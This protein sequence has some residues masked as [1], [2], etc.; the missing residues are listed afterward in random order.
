MN[1][2]RIKA[3][4]ILGIL[5][6][7]VQPSEFYDRFYSEAR[8]YGISLPTEDPDLVR[9]LS[10]LALERVAG[11]E[12]AGGNHKVVCNDYGISYD[13]SYRLRRH[14]RETTVFV[15]TGE[16][17]YQGLGLEIVVQDEPE[18]AFHF[19][20]VSAE[21]EGEVKWSWAEDG[22]EATLNVEAKDIVTIPQLLDYCKVDLEEWEPYDTIIN[23]WPM[24]Y[25]VGSA[26]ERRGEQ[27]ALIQVKVKLKRLVLR[28][29]KFPAL[30]PIKVEVSQV[31]PVLRREKGRLRRAL[32][33]PDPQIGFRRDLRT[34]ELD[35]LH[36]RSAM[37]VALQVATAMQPD[38]I[39]YLGDWLDL[40][41]WST[42][43]LR[44]P[45]FA[46]TTQP[47]CAEGAWWLE[48]FSLACPEAKKY[49]LPGNHEKRVEDAVIAHLEEAFMVTRKGS[50]S[51]PAALSIT[52]MLGLDDM[53]I[54]VCKSYPHGEVWLND[55][56]RVYHGD[57]VRSQSGKTVEAVLKE[58]VTSEVF[59]HIHRLEL[60]SKTRHYRGRI[61]PIYAFS[62]GCLCRVDD[63][64]PAA[65]SR[66]NWQQGVG[67]VDYD[68]EGTAH[69]ISP[70][71][72]S[73]G[74]AIVESGIISARSHEEQISEDTG[75]NFI[76]FRQAA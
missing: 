25:T 21:T 51:A 46:Q 20:T 16:D 26:E 32:I 34:G 72:I 69:A 75:W 19:R 68:P 54:E 1:Y 29:Q 9:F 61:Q 24:G 53:D 74:T 59:G 3:H 17:S 67:I 12:T 14:L 76:S 73:G 2:D 62:P 10:G 22:D 43:F 47:S 70:I 31:R 23:K 65:K 13:K 44:S 38:D 27:I 40:A 64:V 30:R 11:A 8:A 18:V 48:Q 58:A 63:A 4:D 42:K 39:I 28:R 35:P 57:V 56:V 50:V 45:E 71:M 55:A 6:L 52:N 41:A 60:A 66:L 37:D 36:D 49:F 33:V 15:Q 7:S 5:S